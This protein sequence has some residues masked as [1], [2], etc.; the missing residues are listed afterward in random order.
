MSHRAFDGSTAPQT[1]NGVDGYSTTIKAQNA[2]GTNAHGGNLIL[3]GG[4]GYNGDGSIRD[5]YVQ[6]Y[7]GNTE[8]ARAVPNKF[9][10][11]TG[12]R[13]NIVDVS[14]TPF[15]VSD[16]YFAIMVDTSGSAITINLP[17]SPL[18]GDMYRVKD[19]AGNAATNNITLS[20]NGHDIDGNPSLTMNTN[21]GSVTVVYVNTVNKW[22]IID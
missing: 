2:T 1:A 20:G 10:M 17:I 19:S 15:T 6:L 11:V 22:M 13:I 7:S 9:Y 16:G 5:G 18:R 3:K 14:T 21:Y 8:Q 4:D 12:Q